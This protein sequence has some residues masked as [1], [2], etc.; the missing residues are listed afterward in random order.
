VTFTRSGGSG[1]HLSET[2]I[3]PQP[4]HSSAPPGQLPHLGRA[5]AGHHQWPFQLPQGHRRDTRQGCRPPHQSVKNNVLEQDQRGVKGR[6]WPM[7]GFK[8]FAATDRDGAR[9]DGTPSSASPGSGVD[10]YSFTVTDL[11]RRSPAVLSAR[12][13]LTSISFVNGGAYRSS[14]RTIQYRREASGTV[15]LQTDQ[16]VVSDVWGAPSALPARERRM[17]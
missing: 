16:V 15:R 13:D 6:Y 1:G 9:S 12:Q 4:R 3:L 14:R 7:R 2:G 11:P 8:A 10:C 5:R 17:P